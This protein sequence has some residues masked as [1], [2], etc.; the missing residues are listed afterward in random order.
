MLQSGTKHFSR[1]Q[2]CS[3]ND[4]QFQD[5]LYRHVARLAPRVMVPRD[6]ALL[7]LMAKKI[8]VKFIFVGLIGSGS[9]FVGLFAGCFF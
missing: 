1:K 5:L 3:E 8:D 6:N 2:L 7:H 9:I 4:L